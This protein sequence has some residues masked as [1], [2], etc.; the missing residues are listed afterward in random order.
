[1]ILGVRTVE[2]PV[3]GLRLQMERFTAQIVIRK[4]LANGL[5]TDLYRW[6]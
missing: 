1:M 5:G 4:S 6:L 3:K 2:H